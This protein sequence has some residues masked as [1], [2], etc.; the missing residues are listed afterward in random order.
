[1]NV[2]QIDLAKYID[3]TLLKA[4][5]TY[6]DIEKLCKEAV[7]HGFKGVCVNPSFVEY[8]ASLLKGKKTIVVAVVGFPLGATQTATKAFEAK[9]AVAA[10]AQE[11]DMVL[12]ISALKEKNYQLVYQDIC[13]VVNEVK[14]LA[15]KVI[16]ETCYLERDEKIVAST[17]AVVAGAKFIKTSTGFGPAGACVDDI[18][19][20]RSVI[21]DK[22][23]IKASGG[24]KTFEEAM[25]M[26]EAGADRLGI[27]TSV[28]I[29][30]GK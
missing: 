30:M 16:I 4:N 28:N 27:S 17:L 21:D 23:K 2:K 18:K 7:D 20:I 9:E 10:G 29:V 26:V 19:L 24:I 6:E 25:K 12:N 15:V 14:P 5:A 1:M 11:I 3:H 8:A 13:A 22:V